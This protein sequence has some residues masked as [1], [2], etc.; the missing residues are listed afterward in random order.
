M[1]NKITGKVLLI[2]GANRGIGQALVEEAL[3][4]GAKRVYAGTRV[5]MSHPDQRVVPLI[6]DITRPDQI[7]LAAEKAGQLD[8]LINN[9]GVAF[10][11]DLADSS[12]LE[13]HLAVNLYGTQNITNAFLPA[14]KTSHG[15]VV[16]I[17]SILALAPLPPIAS[18]CIS[19]AAAFSMTQSL[20]A[21]LKGRNVS[22]HAVLT[23]PV[24]TEMSRGLTIPKASPESVAHNIFEGVENNR[25]EIF[26]DPMSA[27]MEQ[28]W[29][30]SA[31]KTMQR[32]NALSIPE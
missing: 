29:Y 3:R 2:T 28:N 22:V 17:L 7:R 20:R 31:A 5:P 24:D 23:G 26:P 25:E 27:S 32:Q 4:R 6:L 14:L 30:D 16:N 8:I 21:F 1:K 13:R 11:D 19:K 10:Y 12:I 18:Y 15:T 9:A